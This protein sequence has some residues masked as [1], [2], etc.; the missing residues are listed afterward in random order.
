MPDD[1]RPAELRL[2]T[3]LRV[4]EPCNLLGDSH[5]QTADEIAAWD[6]PARIVRPALLR[7]ILLDE[8]PEICPDFVS[9]RGAVIDRDLDMTGADVRPTVHLTSCRITNA[10]FDGVTFTGGA[11]FSGVTF[12]GDAGFSGATFT[13]NAEFD[14]LITNQCSFDQANFHGRCLG[15]LSGEQWSS[16]RASSTPGYA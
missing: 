15:L 8:Y 12:T 9:L 16:T 14:K 7:A 3:A 5:D 4:G 6:D 13:G 2:L 10:G 1:L 11:G